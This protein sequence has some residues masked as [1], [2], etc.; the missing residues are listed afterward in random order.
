MHIT[1]S[2]SSSWYTNG[3]QT[4]TLDTGVKSTAKSQVNITGGG[5]FPERISTRAEE[6][7][8]ESRDTG[9]EWIS[10]D[11]LEVTLTVVIEIFNCQPLWISAPVYDLWTYHNLTCHHPLRKVFPFGQIQSWLCRLFCVLRSWHRE[12]PCRTHLR[13]SSVVHQVA[14][15]SAIWSLVFSL[16]SSLPIISI[17]IFQW[18]RLFC[19]R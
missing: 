11:W 17:E 15:T 1:L 8:G 19:M 14:V 9:G 18:S 12:Y 5:R 7:F 4:K 16:S 13:D 10:S 2:N 3:K 6:F